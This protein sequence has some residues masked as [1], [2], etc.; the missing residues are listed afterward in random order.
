MSGWQGSPPFEDGSFALLEDD[1]HNYPSIW[2]FKDQR[3]AEEFLGAGRKNQNSVF[4]DDMFFGYFDEEGEWYSD[5]TWSVCKTP[6][7]KQV[8]YVHDMRDWVKPAHW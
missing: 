2:V 4:G 1:G 8:L 6:E 3:T 7:G 5:A